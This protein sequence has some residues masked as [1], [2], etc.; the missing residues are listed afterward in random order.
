MK[1][2]CVWWTILDTIEVSDDATVEEIEE[3]L[4]DCNP[5]EGSLSNREWSYGR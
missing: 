3:L 5:Y 1:K 4:D 2:I